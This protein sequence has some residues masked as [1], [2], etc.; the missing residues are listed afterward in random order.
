MC[1]PKRLI[2]ELA[3]YCRCECACRRGGPPDPYVLSFA[4]TFSLDRN[5]DRQKGL[6]MN[7]LPSV[8]QGGG[9][10]VPTSLECQRSL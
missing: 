6:L 9:G 3:C 2:L 4:G 7:G 8:F 5:H 10:N 1:Q